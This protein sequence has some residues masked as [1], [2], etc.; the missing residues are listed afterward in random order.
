[1][2]HASVASLA[3]VFERRLAGLHDSPV[4]PLARLEL[5]A[6]LVAL[7]LLEIALELLAGLLLFEV[8]AA[9]L[10]ELLLRRSALVASLLELLPELGVGPLGRQRGDADVALAPPRAR[11]RRP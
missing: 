7:A 1:M 4:A 2:R 8:V 6:G 5:A 3:P 9:Q 11:R 10:F